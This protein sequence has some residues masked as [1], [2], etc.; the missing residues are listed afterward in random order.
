MPLALPVTLVL[1]AQTSVNVAETYYD[2]FLGSSAL[3]GVAL[4]FPV[5]MLMTTMAAGGMG[6]GVASAVERVTGTDDVN[7]ASRLR[8]RVLSGICFPTTSLT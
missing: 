6:G 7:G 5:R 4:I 8:S 3:I 2:S 1:I